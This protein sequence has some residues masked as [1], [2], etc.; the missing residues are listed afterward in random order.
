MEIVAAA[1]IVGAAI[2][3][4]LRLVRPAYRGIR[5]FLALAHAVMSLVQAHLAPNGGS[6]LVD[7]VDALNEWK[8]AID[9]RLGRIERCLTRRHGREEGGDH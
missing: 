6:S 8:G 5:G 7:R 4:W 9:E 1:G 2:G 3:A